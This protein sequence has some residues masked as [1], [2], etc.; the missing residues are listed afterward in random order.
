MPA[1]QRVWAHQ[2]RGPGPAR[3]A[4]T[5]CGEDEAVG[6]TPAWLPQLTLKYAQLVAQNEQF[7]P[8][9]RFRPASIHKGTQ[10]QSEE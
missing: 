3:Q 4:S 6:S 2:E 1:E 8:E 10:H 9:R 5:E 7:E